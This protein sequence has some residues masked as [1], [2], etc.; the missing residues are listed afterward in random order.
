MNI[1]TARFNKKRKGFTL[2][3]LLVVI[4]IIVIL[5]AVILV[6]VDPAR[7]LKQARDAVRR[8]DVRDILEAIQ[9][10]M[11]DNDGDIPTGIDADGEGD[12]GVTEFIQILGTGGAA[13]CNGDGGTI[14]TAA[15]TEDNCLD[16]SADLVET[17]LAEIPIDPKGGTYDADLT[18]YYV[19]KSDNDRITVGACNPELATTIKVKR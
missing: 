15:A 17:Y 14:C 19:D 16:L 18:G 5:F 3:E 4:A 7:R 12:I 8:Q 9:E 1:S 11:V 6:A 2:V 13:A 10:S